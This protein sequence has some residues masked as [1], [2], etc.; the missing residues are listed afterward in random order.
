MSR[1]YKLLSEFFSEDKTRVATVRH[2]LGTKNYSVSVTN[3]SGH[4]FSA[5]FETEDDAEQFAEE[6]VLK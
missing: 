4:A 1:A 5:T 6:W 2:E 3:E